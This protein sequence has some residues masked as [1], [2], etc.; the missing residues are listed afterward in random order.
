[1]M[2][3]VASLPSRG[4]PGPLAPDIADSPSESLFVQSST[5]ALNRDFPG[6]DISFLLVD[7]RTGRLLASRWDNSDAPIP[8]GSLVKPFTALAYD[9]QHASQYPIHTCRGIPSG[10]WRLGGHGNVDLRKAIAYSCNSYFRVLTEDLRWGDVATTATHFGLETPDRGAIGAAL[11]GLGP[12]WRISPLRM[13]R[14]YVDLVGLRQE[15][16]VTLIVEGMA[17]SARGGTGS[18]VDQALRRHKALVKTGT[19]MCTHSPRAPG[20]GFTVALVP[21]DDPKI[22]LM[23][24]VH[25][26]PGARA[27]R[28]AGQMLRRIE[29]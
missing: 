14:A 25:G 2:I 11:A 26:V 27:A 28:I 21:A 22:L 8:L 13:A 19:A 4:R 10:C 7:A 12:Q 24:C 16:P 6:R 5:V 15:P 29:D 17:E 18:E 1:M 23:V 20:D 9:V 3:L